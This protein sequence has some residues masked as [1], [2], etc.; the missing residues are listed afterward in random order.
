MAGLYFQVTSGEVALVANTPKTVLQIKAPTNQRVKVK[1]IRIMGKQPAGGTDTP[2]KVR[3]TQSSANFGTSTGAATIGKRNPVD[4]ETI[5]TSAGYNFTAEPTTP[6][7]SG[8]WWEVQPQSGA[9]ESYY[10]GDEIII[11]GGHA[12]NIECTNPGTPTMTVTC[13]CEE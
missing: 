2:T 1:S 7:D 12:L 11:P 10:P 6:T 4:P 13:I 5:Q 9:G 3:L 8:D